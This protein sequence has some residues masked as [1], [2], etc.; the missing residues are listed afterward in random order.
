[1]PLPPSPGAQSRPSVPVTL[2]EVAARLDAPLRSPGRELDIKSLRRRDLLACSLLGR[3]GSAA[4][5]LRAGSFPPAE[6]R[7]LPSDELRRLCPGCDGGLSPPPHRRQ[8][9]RHGSDAYHS[10][11]RS[12]MA[13]SPHASYMHA[14]ELATHTPKQSPR[15]RRCTVALSASTLASIS[16]M[17]TRV[18]AASASRLRDRTPCLA[19]VVTCCSNAVC[20]AS[21]RALAVA[22]SCSARLRMSATFRCA[23]LDARSN[24]LTLFMCASIAAA[25]LA[26]GRPR[27]RSC[28]VEAARR[29]DR[30]T[31]GLAIVLPR[32]ARPPVSSRLA[33]APLS[34]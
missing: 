26:D 8:T 30:G 3:R 34:A 6:L 11:H 4:G 22:S 18:A 14:H 13:H 28:Q 1:M 17:A 5:V 29:T 32:R 27:A 7:D 15:A 33:A 21:T 16:F 9:R 10:T 19:I 25:C 20:C 31:A 23:C 24:S 2:D 12:A